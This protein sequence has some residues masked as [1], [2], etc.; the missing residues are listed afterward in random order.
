MIKF[1]CGKCEKKIGVP[2]DYAGK[3][4][5][6]P[7]CKQPV[8]VPEIELEPA[9][10]PTPDSLGADDLLGSDYASDMEP[11]KFDFPLQP[12]AQTPAPKKPAELRC[13]KCLTVI[14]EGSEFCITCGHPAPLPAAAVKKEEPK[15]SGILRSIPMGKGF[16][17][18]LMSMISPMK[19]GTDMIVFFVLFF[20]HLL[21]NIPFFIPLYVKVVVLG[22]IYTYLFDVLLETA[23]GDNH[24]PMFEMPETMFEVVKPFFQM[25]ASFLYAFSPLVIWLAVGVMSVSNELD[26][27][28]DPGYDF[29]NIPIEQKYDDVPTGMEKEPNDQVL[30][31]M[32]NEEEENFY[33]SYEEDESYFMGYVLLPLGIFVAG[34]FFWPMIVL[35]IVLGNVFLPN[36]VKVIQN[37]GRTI[38]PYLICCGIMYLTSM[39]I[40]LSIF[41]F[42]LIG[43][44]E[45]SSFVLILAVISSLV[46]SLCI[47]IYAMRVL[48]LLYR[49]YEE[50]LDW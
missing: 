9:E 19:S 26:D 43:L 25:I 17:T 50:R 44:F 49:H 11:P 33:D 31:D 28:E 36:P 18:D 32:L 13:S 10:E 38:K 5:K 7:R 8:R 15:K 40:W 23:N 42:T 12:D 6:C 14:P 30:F 39:L 16:V 1:L 46:G 41:K 24:L 48:G 47:E 35:N 3:L 37:I 29:S 34:M 2:D 22:L 21:S 45:G 20:L 27:Y 4:V